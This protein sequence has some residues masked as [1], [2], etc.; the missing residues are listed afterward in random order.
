[1]S[2][3]VHRCFKGEFRPTP[4]AL[5]EPDY[6]PLFLGP[7]GWS[8]IW[9]LAQNSKIWNLKLP[10]PENSKT[11]YVLSSFVPTSIKARVGFLLARLGRASDPSPRPLCARVRVSGGVRAWHWR[12]RSRGQQRREGQSRSRQEKPRPEPGPCESKIRNASE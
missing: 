4:N 12:R 5:F 10:T 2:T 7:G 8:A 9:I 11:G 6:S 3:S 1:M